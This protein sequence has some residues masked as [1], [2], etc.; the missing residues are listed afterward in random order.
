[1]TNQNKKKRKI[2]FDEAI[3]KGTVFK[4][5][6]EDLVLETREGNL[7]FDRR[8]TEEPDES[9]VK[10]IM[11]QG[12]ISPIS[13][14]KSEDGRPLVVA[15]RRRVIAAREANR[16]LEKQGKPAIITVPCV[17]SNGKS[18][19]DLFG[20]YVSENSLR[21]DDTP[22]SKARNAAKLMM[23]SDSIERTAIIMG[24][25]T[26]TITNW[27]RLLELSETVQKAVDNS[28]ISAS[29]ALELH[30]MSFKDQD[31]TIEKVKQEPP[32]KGRKKGKVTAS[33]VSKAAGKP[34]R[35]MRSR[36]EI[37]KRLVEVEGSSDQHSLVEVEVLKWVLMH[38][39]EGEN[40]P[41]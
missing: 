13:V 28:E 31:E 16:R 7:L 1:M 15:G 39:D 19:V 2:L 20:V 33:E 41:S 3:G 9:L 36:K 14:I 35:K 29:A 38:T 10:N 8:A 5:P 26:Q 12:I 6:P 32:A 25:T 4:I 30:G 11:Y 18:D 24:V 17:K 34:R 40:E 22:L 27:M 37:T 21:R 23:L